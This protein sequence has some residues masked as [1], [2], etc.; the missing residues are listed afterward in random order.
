MPQLRPGW[1]LSLG[2]AAGLLVL[3][4]A[5]TLLGRRRPRAWTAAVTAFSR[6]FTVIMLL[7]AVWQYVGAYVHSHVAGAM[8]R[9]HRISEWQAAWHLPS[10]LSVQRLMLQVPHLSDAADLYYAYAHLNGTAVFVVWL[11]WRHRTAYPRA[12]FVIVASTLACLLVQSV[13]VAPP[14]LLPELGFVDTALLD[15]RSVYGEFGSGMANQLAAMPSVHV[16]WAVIVGWYVWWCAGPRWRWVGPAHTVLT[17]LVVVATANHWWLDGLV[18][19]GFVA[20]AGLA[21]RVVE[22][23]RAGRPHDDAGP[24]PS[25][26]APGADVVPGGDPDPRPDLAPA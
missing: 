14:R 9:G 11:W 1:P 21:R 18:A 12:R 24:A 2:T 6:E 8:E 26:R 19:A 4:L 22:G 25:G 7:L 3:F 13:P 15:G 16:C 5:C 10:E 17:V 20:L 23:V